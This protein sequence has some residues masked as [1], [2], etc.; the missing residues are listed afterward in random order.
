MQLN[1]LHTAYISYPIQVAIKKFAII[2]EGFQKDNFYFVAYF[3]KLFKS[4]NFIYNKF[5]S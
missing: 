2:N 1:L 4:N 5:Y 3:N